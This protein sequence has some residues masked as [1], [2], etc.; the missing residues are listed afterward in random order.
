VPVFLFVLAGDAAC[1]LRRGMQPR[2]GNLGAAGYAQAVAAGVD[3]VQ[4]FVNL[5]QLESLALVE[6]EF[7]FTLGAD[8]RGRI[9]GVL[10]MLGRDFGPAD[11]TATLFG[12]LLQQGC[13]PGQKF[14][15]EGGEE[16]LVHKRGFLESRFHLAPCGCA[17]L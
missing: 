13:A 9:L 16:V 8:L 6:G 5:S 15:F 17:G 7:E 3:A 12:H 11:R 1:R 14:F 4:G 2:G 10:K